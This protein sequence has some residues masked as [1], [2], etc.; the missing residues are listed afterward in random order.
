M[1]SG[2]RVLY[3][4]SFVPPAGI[5]FPHIDQRW[6]WQ[7][8]GDTGLFS[9]AAR[10]DP[11]EFLSFEPGGLEE[12]REYLCLRRL[13]ADGPQSRAERWRPDPGIGIP[14]RHSPGRTFHDPMA[15]HASGPLLED[16]PLLEGR[17]VPKLSF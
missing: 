17:H 3:Q 1:G 5:H 13:V 6:P 7:P 4:V 8:T 14:W 16:R 2:Y 11:G 12:S 10:R 9:P 15:A